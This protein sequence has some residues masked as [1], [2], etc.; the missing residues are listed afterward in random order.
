MSTKLLYSLSDENPD[1]QKQI[2]CMNG[3]FNI[4]DRHHFLSGRRFANHN[5]KRLPPG[6]NDNH[7]IKPHSASQRPKDKIPKK[8]VK[9]KTKISTESSRTSFS[10]SPCSS[11][12]SSIECNKQQSQ[13]ETSLS[14]QANFLGTPTRNLPTYKPSDSSQLSQQHVDI[15]DVV[16]DSMQREA[17]ELSIKTA[18]KANAGGQ[19][20]KYMDSPRPVHLQQPKTVKSRVSGL[21]ESFRLLPNK[22]RETPLRKDG[23]TLKDAP[24]FSYDGRESRDAFKS[25]I[26]IKELPRLS[27][28]SRER[29][30]MS[31]NIEM[32]SNNLFE[33]LHRRNGKP[34]HIFDQQQE[35]GSYKRPSSVVAKLMGLEAFPEP[36]LANG[37]QQ[38]QMQTFPDVECDSCLQSSRPTDEIKHNRISGSPRNSRKEPVSRRTRNADSIKKPIASSKFPIET[39]P[40]RQPDGNKGQT[41]TSKSQ[42]TPA[43]T[44]NSPLSVYGEIK[45]RLSQLEF[46]KSGKDLR[47][48]KQILEAMQKT[49]EMLESRKDQASN[50]V[51]QTG[52]NSSVYRSSKLDVKGDNPSYTTFKGTSSPKCFKSPIVIMKAAKSIEKAEDSVSSANLTENLSGLQRRLRIGDSADNRKEA[53]DRRTTKD[54]TPK[55]IQ[56]REP[57]SRLI[58]P[59]NKNNSTETPRSAQTSKSPYTTIG[60]NKSAKSSELMNPRLQQKKLGFEMQSH[61]TYPLSDLSRTTR[62]VTESSSPSRKSGPK[63]PNLQQKGT[64]SYY[65]SND[66]RDF[67]HQDDTTSLKSESNISMVSHIESEVTSTDRS[68]MV[69]DSFQQHGLKVGLNTLAQPHTIWILL[70]SAFISAIQDPETWYTEDRSTIEPVKVG[71]EQPSPVSVLDATF[72]RD[73]PPSPVKKISHI[74]NDDEALNS[75]EAEWRLMDLNHSPSSG[76]PS[77]SSENNYGKVQNLMHIYPPHKDSIIDAIALIN[78]STDPDNRYISEILLASGLLRDV[79]SDFMSFQLLPSGHLIHPNL[80]LLLEQ[81]QEST[82][83][84]NAEHKVKK[85]IHSETTNEK[86]HRKLIF[87][88]VNEILVHKLLLEGSS[89]QWVSPSKLVGK[90]PR[91]QQLLRD[92]CKEVDRLQANNSNCSLDDEEDCLTSIIWEDLMHGSINWTDCQSEISWLALDVEQL[93]F[94]DLITEIVRDE[95]T[96]LHCQ[97]GRHCRQ[98][99]SN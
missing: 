3:I 56:L 70:L 48:L 81:Y 25:T 42:E 38:G 9:E 26:K 85:T 92:L 99:F 7:E 59:K 76:K 72:Y 71:G 91:Q 86:D 21:N 97:P 46:K 90:R 73:E 89:K 36:M 31:S 23:F 55:T 78:N 87:D 30:M 64:Q 74:F 84:L 4:F 27:L 79:E 10:S 34:K 29:S 20:L 69:G 44:P 35:P 51:S 75:N 62:Q 37:N 41:P 15:R 32:E 63:S 94:K 68:D 57:S 66:A 80:F 88:T 93:I 16:K 33:D 60:K 22:L 65:I 96:S 1:L 19:T 13:T 5:Q 98:L 95:T 52:N 14:G 18:T 54:Q 50:F 40:W 8:T 45:K 47:A 24:R 82:R 67:R 58:H 2:G 6:Q 12:L 83:L 77:F 53:V 11:S 17:R 39:A 49:K 43:K 28:D 61:P